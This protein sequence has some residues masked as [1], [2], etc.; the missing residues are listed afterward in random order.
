MK[1]SRSFLPRKIRSKSRA[2]QSFVE[3][4]ARSAINLTFTFNCSESSMVAVRSRGATSPNARQSGR[5][6]LTDS[7]LM[8]RIYLRQRVEIGKKLLRIK[9]RFCSLTRRQTTITTLLKTR[10]VVVKDH[11]RIPPTN[12]TGKKNCTKRCE[13]FWRYYFLWHFQLA[14]VPTSLIYKT[15]SL[16]KPGPFSVARRKRRHHLRMIQWC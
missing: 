3:R 10:K 11:L 6:S 2:R 5:L 7:M 1:I 15:K 14:L 16:H 4:L 12:S 13:A 8:L 9:I